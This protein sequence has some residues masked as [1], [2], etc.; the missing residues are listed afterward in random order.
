MHDTQ[1]SAADNGGKNQL[2]RSYKESIIAI[3][4]LAVIFC[5]S[6]YLKFSPGMKWPGYDASEYHYVA[7][8][9]VAGNGLEVNVAGQFY[10]RPPSVKHKIIPFHMPLN[11]YLLAASYKLFGINSPGGGV[12]CAVGGARGAAVILDFILGLAVFFVAKRLSGQDILAAFFA[13][14]IYM[15]HTTTLSARS[16][17]GAAAGFAMFFGFFFAWFAYKSI[18]NPVNFIPAGIFGALSYLI[19]NEGLFTIAGLIA[20]YFFA[21]KTHGKKKLLPYFLAGTFIIVATFVLWEVRNYSL[22]GHSAAASRYNM[23]FGRDYYDMWRYYPEPSSVWN[24]VSEYLKIGLPKIII[25]KIQSYHYKIMWGMDAVGFPLA[26]FLIAGVAASSSL[27]KKILIAPLAY[28]VVTYIFFGFFN[29]HSQQWGWYAAEVFLPLWTIVAVMGCFNLPL[30]ILMEKSSLTRRAAGICC[31]SLILI[32]YLACA[33]RDYFKNK[34]SPSDPVAEL[35]AEVNRFRLDNSDPVI[36]T[37]IP[38]LFNYFYPDIKSVQIPTNEP[39]EVI[40]EV[41]EKYDC[42]YLV[43]Y[44]VIPSAYPFAFKDIYYGTGNMD[45]FTEV[46][47]KPNP[48]GLALEGAGGTLKIFKIENNKSLSLRERKR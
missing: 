17:G 33:A 18:E 42:R 20:V 31:A 6:C 48:T 1:S 46:F 5:L 35:A 22:F 45:G 27:D 10:P 39:I 34:K 12:G 19:R 25:T 37:H 26:L 9:I 41:A 30:K 11:Y 14:A 24:F 32:F 3:L 38:Y 40:R 7:K 8:N 21:L 43:L 23:M 44:G 36:M 2:Q 16:S 15:T 47:S 28:F 13:S 29:A 4:L